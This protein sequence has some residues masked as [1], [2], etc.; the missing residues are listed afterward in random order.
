MNYQEKW[1]RSFAFR[2]AGYTTVEDHKNLSLECVA[3]FIF[4]GEILNSPFEIKYHQFGLVRSGSPLHAR[5][6]MSEFI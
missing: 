2:M 4:I 5:S 6:V 3:I 1:D